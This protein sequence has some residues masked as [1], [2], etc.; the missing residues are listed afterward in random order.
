MSTEWTSQQQGRSVV[1][2]KTLYSL[3]QPLSKEMV[4]GQRTPKHEPVYNLWQ[5]TRQIHALK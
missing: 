3:I 5:H 1:A 2:N 4:S